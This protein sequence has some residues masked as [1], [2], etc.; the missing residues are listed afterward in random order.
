M[1]S[2]NFIAAAPLQIRGPGLLIRTRMTV[3]P[4]APVLTPMSV[5]PPV[6]RWGGGG[7]D[8]FVLWRRRHLLLLLLLLQLLLRRVLSRSCHGLLVRRGLLHI[9]RNFEAHVLVERRWLEVPGKVRG[10]ALLL[11]L[12]LCWLQHVAAA[13]GR[14]HC[15][16][17]SAQP[18]SPMKI[19]QF[20]ISFSPAS[21]LLYSLSPPLQEPDQEFA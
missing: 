21:E 5:P 4:A 6:P 15:G 9:G 3:A 7:S 8:V 10:R 17:G 19:Q 13:E 1:S 11:L 14:G 20:S 18:G 16:G 2:Q 12:L